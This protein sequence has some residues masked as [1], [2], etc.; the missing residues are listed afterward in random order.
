MRHP[1]VPHR[2]SGL[3]LEQ[4]GEALVRRLC[5]TWQGKSGMC[6]CPAHADRH[7]SLSVR[8]GDRALIFKCFAGC[9]SAA[10]ARAIARIDPHALDRAPKPSVGAAIEGRARRRQYACNVWATAVPL[11]GSIAS[12]YLRARGIHLR[13]PNLRFNPHTPLRHGEGLTR[14][15][16]LIAAVTDRGALVAIHRTFLDPACPRLARDLSQPRRMLGRPGGGAV[17][18]APA[19]DCLGLA[20]GIE[21]ALSAMILF[22]VPV[23]AAL[24]TE[25]LSQVVVP[26]SVQHLLLFADNDPGGSRAAARAAQAHARAGRVVETCSPPLAFNDWNDVLQAGGK[27]EGILR[28]H[29]V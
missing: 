13:A 14:R 5:G 22:G 25:R 29:A 20:E 21:T 9:S 11:G 16:A 26:D 3:A 1:I 17:A 15:P 8:I 2:E 19:T 24:G 28:R 10:V 12:S 6:L 18:L 23:W 27:G 7:P 4:A